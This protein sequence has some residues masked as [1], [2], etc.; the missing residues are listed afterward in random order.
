MLNPVTES[1]TS[2]GKS[3]VI[4]YGCV[5]MQG[6]RKTME[7]THFAT[8]NFCD[9]ETLSFFAVYDGHG[10]SEVSRWLSVHLHRMVESFYRASCGRIDEALTKAFLSVDD[11]LDTWYR[12]ADDSNSMGQECLLKKLQEIRDSQLSEA[13]EL[14]SSTSSCSSTEL[15]MTTRPSSSSQG[16]P[17]LRPSLSPPLSSPSPE[18]E[19]KSTRPSL[20]LSPSSP[21]HVCEKKGLRPSLS[22]EMIL[23]SNYNYGREYGWDVGSTACAAVVSENRI[24]VANVGDSRCVLSRDGEA[25]DL[26]IDH[27]PN[28][29]REKARIEAAGLDV[30]DGRVRGELNLSRALGD[31]RFKNN[32]RLCSTQQAVTAVPDVACVDIQPD[33]DFLVI[34]S[35]G[36]FDVLSSQEVVQFVQEHLI[37]KKE[38]ILSVAE[39]LVRHCIA[40]SREGYVGGSGM[41]NMTAVIVDLRVRR[42]GSG[43]CFGTRFLDCPKKR[44]LD[45]K[46]A[47]F[48]QNKRQSPLQQYQKSLRPQPS[49]VGD[50]EMSVDEP[51]HSEQVH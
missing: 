38:A 47:F 14:A 30:E 3:K 41:D 4:E 10:G 17:S 25:I 36:I 9:D 32:C 23:C 51:I 37:R 1:S 8:N 11:N 43:G 39:E 18:T 19:R 27:K 20:S 7:D 6:W 29:P 35:D 28:T 26:S 50:T 48:P 22:E 2:Y 40:P 24:Y 5:E 12:H 44:L 15:E 45:G 13:S 16:R 49:W 42:S 31:L 21:V 33:H 46:F 34:A